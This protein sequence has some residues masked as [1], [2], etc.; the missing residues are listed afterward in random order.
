MERIAF[1]AV[2]LI[3]FLSRTVDARSGGEGEPNTRLEPFEAEKGLLYIKDAYGLGGITLEVF[4]EPDLVIKERQRHAKEMSFQAL[5]FYVP[6]R[7]N[8]K[9]RFL[10]IHGLGRVVT[11][12]MGQLEEIVGTIRHI[13]ALSERWRTIEK[14]DTEAIFRAQDDF[15]LRLHQTGSSQ[16]FMVFFGD[17]SLSVA[18]ESLEHLKNK[19]EE[20]LSFLKA[21]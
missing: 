6:G 7:E 10:R 14:E 5:V 18:K 1:A 17:L 20:G 11:L 21:K 12:E 4:V 16:R 13:L 9:S 2:V 3:L 15:E 19:I 8:E